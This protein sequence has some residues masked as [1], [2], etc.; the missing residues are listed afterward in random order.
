[1]KIIH[2]KTKTLKTRDNGRSSDA[3]SPNFIYGCLGS[4]LKSYCFVARYN[5]DKVY[6]NENTEQ[7]LQ[8]IE[9]W[10]SDKPDKIPN[11]VS[12]KYYM[13][14][15]G[16][17]TDVALHGKHYDWQKVFDY[18]NNHERLKFT[19]AT[20]YPSLFGNYEI[21]KDNRIRISLMPQLYADVLEPKCDSINKRIDQIGRL[22]EIMEVHLNFSP[23]IYEDGWLEQ[24]ES[25]F[26][27]VEP[28]SSPLLKSEV[29]F[30]TYNQ[31]SFERNSEVVNSLLWKPDIQELKNSEYADNNLRY[32][33]QLK[34]QLVEQFKELHNK[35]LG[36][37]IRYI[38]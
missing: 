9:K 4:C 28:F 7:I 13:I 32:K 38:F 33:W 24:Y 31:K 17:S 10:V 21:H 29:I 2:Q 22:R 30:L 12:D 6:V 16:C 25:L 15:I 35:Y 27:F 26:K 3:I 5:Y 37:T 14:D 1:M 36:N 8:S 19:F 18:F 34:Q 23:V 11:Q 20:K